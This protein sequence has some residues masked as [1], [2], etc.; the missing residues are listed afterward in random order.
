MLENSKRTDVA[1]E[2]S[3]TLA[4]PRWTELV[5]K[6]RADWSPAVDWFTTRKGRVAYKKY[7]AQSAQVDLL[8]VP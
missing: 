6:T 8:L 7:T 5:P 4:E 3:L 1:A 2:G